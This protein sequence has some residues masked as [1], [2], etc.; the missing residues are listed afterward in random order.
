M[1]TARQAKPTPK[2]SG[3]LFLLPFPPTTTPQGSDHFKPA[4][5][6]KRRMSIF[7]LPPLLLLYTRFL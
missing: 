7:S 2:G 3:W 4:S 1:Q 5:K 6:T